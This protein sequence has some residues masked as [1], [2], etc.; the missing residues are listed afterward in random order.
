MAF[1]DCPDVRDRPPEQGT[2]D[3]LGAEFDVGENRFGDR[4]SGSF[5]GFFG[6]DSEYADRSDVL[7]TEGFVDLLVDRDLFEL[8]G[9]VLAFH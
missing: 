8:L 6:T 5:D 1:V 7:C 2:N 3:G 4:V 9:A